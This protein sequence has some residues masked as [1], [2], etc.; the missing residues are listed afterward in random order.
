MVIAA[1]VVLFVGFILIICYPINK[2]KNARCTEQ[3]QGMLIDILRRRNSKGNLKS[4]HVYSYNVDGVAYQLRT[5]DYSPQAHRIGDECTIWYNPTKPKD[6]QAF[7]GSDKYLKILLLIGIGLFLL[8]ILLLFLS[9][10]LT[11]S[12]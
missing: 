9:L 4:M 5:L 10:V 6:A 3:T 2:R 12:S 1:V 8:G 11:Y 7:R